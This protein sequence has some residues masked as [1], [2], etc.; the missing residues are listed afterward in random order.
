MVFSG[1]GWNDETRKLYKLVNIPAYWL[2]D[3]KGILRHVGL[4]GE[5]LKQAI[6]NLLKE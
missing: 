1:K 6:L 3:K 2:V 5:E 4:E